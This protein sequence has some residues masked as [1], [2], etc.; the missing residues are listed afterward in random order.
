MVWFI[1][2]ILLA[3]GNLNYSVLFGIVIIAALSEAMFGF[4][5][6]AVLRSIVTE[7]KAFAAAQSVNQAR[8]A[9]INLLGGPVGGLLYAT[10]HWLPFGVTAGALLLLGTAAMLIK[11]NLSVVE[12]T[13]GN[14]APAETVSAE[15]Q[16]VLLSQGIIS[17]WKDLTG[18]FQLVFFDAVKRPI[19]IVSAL[20]G[21][22]S[23][24]VMTLIIYKLIELH[25]TAFQISLV[26]VAAAIGM[27]V[28]AS[29]S[30]ILMNKISTGF[31]VIA[32]LIVICLDFF[33][34]ALLPS[35]GFLFVWFAIYGLCMPIVSAPM[36]GY[37]YART[38]SAMQGRS[39]A[40]MTVFGM[41][42][43][44]FAPVVSG[45]LVTAGHQIPGLFTGAILMAICVAVFCASA[46]VRGIGLPETW[47][48]QG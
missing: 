2:T 27:L 43:G 17:V 18:G 3:T 25:Y 26:E 5:D 15:K 37:F 6:D 44:S 19:A 13:E 11:T 30:G 28:G 36:L 32:T 34:F 22:S 1:A 8:R 10:L 24:L 14:T 29:L 39:A 40:I 41:G 4:A 9:I 48:S 20:M 38:P 45:A 31:L 33:A 7:D 47:A 12:E 23:T 21:F 46:K 16:K 35:Y 42:I